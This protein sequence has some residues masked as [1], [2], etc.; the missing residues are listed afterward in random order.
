MRSVR[1]GLGAYDPSVLLA[2]APTRG[3][4]IAAELGRLERARTTVLLDA[5]EPIA[6]GEPKPFLTTAP[7][8]VYALSQSN[9][10]KKTAVVRGKLLSDAVMLT[11][12]SSE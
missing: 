2:S 9:D 3:E 8:S 11:K 4:R 6:G 1:H 10:G 5:L 12:I 7:D